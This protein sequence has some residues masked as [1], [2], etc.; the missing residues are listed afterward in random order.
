M[1]ISLDYLP[2]TYDELPVSKIFDIGNDYMFEFV[3]NP[4]IDRVSMYIRDTEGTL[5]YT[6]RITYGRKLNHATVEG[7]ELNQDIYAI[8]LDDVVS[9]LTLDS[10]LTVVA[11]GTFGDPV[12]LYLI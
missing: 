12:K 8:N 7:L 10:S 4:R 9:D 1:A 5:L 6:T 3:H 11:S 2:V